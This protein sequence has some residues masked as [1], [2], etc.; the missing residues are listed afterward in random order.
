M[1]WARSLNKI[2]S[3]FLHHLNSLISNVSIRLEKA[4]THK[5]INSK[6]TQI[7]AKKIS[8]EQLEKLLVEDL[9]IKEKSKK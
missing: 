8:A 3:I 5:L 9:K 7:V 1:I 6:K 4:N 2:S